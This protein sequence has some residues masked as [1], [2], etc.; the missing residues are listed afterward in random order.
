[1]GRG[2][3]GKE[4]TGKGWGWEGSGKNR[5]GG[6]R[7]GKG[8]K[9]HGRDSKEWEGLQKDGKVL[10]EMGRKLVKL[11]SKFSVLAPVQYH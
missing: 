1:M 10:K 11:F 2:G 8:Q 4:G 5:N 6:G 3:E 7:E 9:L